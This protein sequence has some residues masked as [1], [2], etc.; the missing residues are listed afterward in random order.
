MTAS[1]H[2]SALDAPVLAR[3]SEAEAEIV[4]AAR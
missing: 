3:V 2:T 4:L 1:V